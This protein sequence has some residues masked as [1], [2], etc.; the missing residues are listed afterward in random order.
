VTNESGVPEPPRAPWIARMAMR[1]LLDERERAAVLGDLRE[2]FEMR[3][4]RDGLEG[5][6]RWYAKQLRRYPARLFAERAARAFRYGPRGSRASAR[7]SDRKPGFL[8][9]FAGDA[10]HAA[11]CVALISRISISRVMPKS[12][13]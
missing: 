2:L 12:G 3:S 8:S 7:G 4:G 11:R 6:R 10:R 9:G 5:A 13:V 1:V